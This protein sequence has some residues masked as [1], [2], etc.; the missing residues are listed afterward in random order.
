MLKRRG[1]RQKRGVYLHL[2]G[3]SVN[4]GIVLIVCKKKK[5]GKKESKFLKSFC[6]S[7]Y[8]NL[9]SSSSSPPPASSSLVFNGGRTACVQVQFSLQLD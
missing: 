4:I 3:L 2:P 1:E 5:M 7:F 6:V 9:Y 8:E